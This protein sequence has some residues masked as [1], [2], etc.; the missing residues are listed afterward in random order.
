MFSKKKDLVFI[1]N[2]EKRVALHM[3]FVFFSIDVIYL[4]KHK[5]IVEIKESFQPFS[6][7]MPKHKAQ[8][9]VELSQETVKKTNTQVNDY[10]GFH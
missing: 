3:F 7:Y 10:L 4:D 6:C 8:Y 9:V 1:F 2:K 5:K